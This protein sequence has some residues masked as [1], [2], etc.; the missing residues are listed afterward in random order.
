MLY[1]R[2]AKLK[3]DIQESTMAI[4]KKS[5]IGKASAKNSTKNKT[6]QTKVASPVAPG[7]MVPAVKL[8]KAALMQT[9]MVVR[10]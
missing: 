5:I 6:A 8:A 2:R 4:A 9:G 3:S 10:F 7:K 1:R